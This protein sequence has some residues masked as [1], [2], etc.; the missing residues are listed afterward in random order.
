MADSF[1]TQK[2]VSDSRF[3]AMLAGRPPLVAGVT[4]GI[5]AVVTVICWFVVPSMDVVGVVTTLATLWAMVLALVIYLLTAKDTDKLLEHIDALQDQLSAAL[6]GP[7]AGAVV[8][9]TEA[10]LEP[11]AVP[12]QTPAPTPHSQLEGWV[13]R[14]A[15]RLPPDYLEALRQWT[16]INAEDI[17]RAWTP[18][19]GGRGPWVVEAADGDRWSVFQGRGGRPTVIPLGNAAQ[20]RQR[21]EAIQQR[22]QAMRAVKAASRP[23][24]S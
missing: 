13:D 1:D 14:L 23:T 12:V 15:G 17:T 24:R 10:P 20:A 22:I 5:A 3:V 4:F 21:H 19:P 9:D 16:E 2:D 8:V 7:G 18:N 11:S 6:E